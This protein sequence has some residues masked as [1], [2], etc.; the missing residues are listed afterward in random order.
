MTRAQYILQTLHEY[1]DDDWKPK[2]KGDFGKN[3]VHAGIGAGLLAGAYHYGMKNRPINVHL[4]APQ[5]T[6]EPHAQTLLH[7]SSHN[8][9]PHHN[10]FVEVPP[11]PGQEHMR[12]FINPETF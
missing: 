10:G 3:L 6:N 4:N 12:H 8:I 5:S 9:G 7:Q 11:T 2:K 1:Y